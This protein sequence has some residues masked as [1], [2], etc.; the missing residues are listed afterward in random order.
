MSWGLEDVGGSWKT[1]FDKTGTCSLSNCL[2]CGGHSGPCSKQ[3]GRLL[4]IS[5]KNRPLR[6]WMQTR[7]LGKYRLEYYHHYPYPHRL[8]TDVIIVAWCF[9]CK[10]YLNACYTLLYMGKYGLWH[11]MTMR[12][13]NVIP[14]IWA[15]PKNN[16]HS[17]N[18]PKTWTFQITFSLY[19]IF[20]QTDVCHG[21]NMVYECI[22]CYMRG[23]VIPSSLETPYNGI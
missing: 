18:T 16:G 8:C 7:K 5:E 22:W 23:V 4:N 19:S 15:C 11:A 6:H 3:H 20:G 17:L 2:Y 10:M 12:A 9:L 21:Q 13:G 14:Y 1:D